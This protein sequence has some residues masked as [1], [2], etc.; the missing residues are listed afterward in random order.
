MALRRLA[1]FHVSERLGQ[2][3]QLRPEGRL[4]D[5]DQALQERGNHFIPLGLGQ[6][7][8][9]SLSTGRPKVVLF[10]VQLAELDQLAEPLPAALEPML[11]FIALAGFDELVDALGPLAARGYRRLRS[12]PV[13]V[14][15]LAPRP[16]RGASVVPQR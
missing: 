4:G 12:L 9:A 11:L 2:S 8:P 15:L 6:A 10:F 1:L 5:A 3:R 16:V 7:L 14:I 13:R